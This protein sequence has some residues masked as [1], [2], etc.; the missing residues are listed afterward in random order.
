LPVG[1]LAC[2]E[3]G[4]LL[5]GDGVVIEAEGTP[6]LCPNPS[7]GVANQTYDRVCRR[8]S[9]PLPT[10]SG[11][12]LHGRYRIEKLVG[13][14][15]FGAVYLAT[16]VKQNN[17]PVAIKDMICVEP[18]EYAVRLSFFQR[19]AEILRQLAAVPVVPKVYDFVRQGQSAYLVMEYIQGQDLLK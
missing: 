3:C 18:Q 4:Y 13:I 5:Q 12:L 2:T 14:G 9:S 10:P 19:E 8:C 15:G 16:D 1:A 6:N 17:R 7:C 11:T